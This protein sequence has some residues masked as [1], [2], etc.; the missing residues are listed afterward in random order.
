M[1]KNILFSLLLAFVGI[2]GSQAAEPPFT[3]P[4]EFSVEMEITSQNGPKM[5]NKMFVSDQKSRM[6]SNMGG[7]QMMMITRL[8][9]RVAYHIMPAQKS[10]MEMPLPAQAPKSFGPPPDATWKDLGSEKIDGVDCEKYEATIQPQ[11][12]PQP[13]KMIHWIRK[14]N[15]ILMRVST[16]NST[17]DW[18]NLKVGKQDAGLFE[19]PSGYKKM[20]MP[21]S[22]ATDM[23]QPPVS[24]KK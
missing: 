8:D 4:K 15:Q 23:Q 19:V 18:R 6:E 2:N 7:Q 24:S 17:T 10:Y 9:K 22:P 20:E 1:M 21:M 12:L 14:D 3:M 13:V 11:G 16:P 5:T